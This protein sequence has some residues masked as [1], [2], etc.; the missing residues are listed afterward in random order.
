[1]TLYMLDTDTASGAIRGHATLDSRLTSLSARSWCISAVTR[2]ELRFGLALRP[3]A[4]KLARLVQAFLDTAW[5][6][7]WDESAADHHGTLR[8][9]LRTSGSPIGDF[10]EMIA[11]H[12]LSLDGILVTGNL[13]HFSRVPG[14]R[15]ENWLRPSST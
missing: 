2:A 8:A 6:A 12:C 15:V 4:R 7:P 3:Q 14:L 9:L 5:T 10:D 13:Q 1:M 11:A